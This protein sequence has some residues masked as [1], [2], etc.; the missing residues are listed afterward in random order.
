MPATLCREYC[1][2]RYSVGRRWHW[3]RLTTVAGADETS[4]A[5]QSEIFYRPELELGQF[6]EHH[7]RDFQPH[8]GCAEPA[9]R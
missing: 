4:P 9:C 2:G 3:F 1:P 5:G 8:V 7:A 6:Q